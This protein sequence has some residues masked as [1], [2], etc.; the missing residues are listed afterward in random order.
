MIPDDTQ[1]DE[2]ALATRMTQDP[3]VQEYRAFFRPVGLAPGAR[4]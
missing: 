2:Q 1:L 4:T 3:V